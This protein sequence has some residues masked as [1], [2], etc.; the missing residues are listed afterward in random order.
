MKRCLKNRKHKKTRIKTKK[1]IKN[2]EMLLRECR[3]SG[4]L[5]PVMPQDVVT[6]NNEAPHKGV[7]KDVPGVVVSV[8][9]YDQ[10]IGSMGHLCQC[11]N[12]ML[13]SALS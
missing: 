13:K 12:N 3:E 10:K 1:Q 7:S 2:I 4:Y 9:D 8:E 5:L 6:D 11:A